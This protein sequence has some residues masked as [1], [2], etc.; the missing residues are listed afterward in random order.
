MKK[1][2]AST[3]RAMLAKV[4]V[5]AMV[6]MAFAVVAPKATA[7]A[8]AKPA[9]T[10]TSRNILVG[11][12]YDLGVKNAPAGSTYVWKTSNKKVATVDKK[13]VVVAKSKGK[14]TITCTVTDSKKKTYKL[15]CKVTVIKPANKV[16][17]SNEATVLNL[18]QKYDLN[19]TVIPASS[20]DTVSWTSDDKTIAAP[21]KNG[22]FTALKQGTVTITAKTLSGKKVSVTIEVVDAEGLVA[23]QA[24]LNKMLG[25]GA[26]VITLKTDA[27]EDFVI[28]NGDYSNQKL[29][30]DVPN[31][32]V[33]NN[34]NFASIEIKN[35]KADTWYEGAKGNNIEVTSN[36]VRIYVNAGAS[37]GIVVKRVGS[38]IVLVNDGVVTELSVE[39]A[40]N[41]EIIGTS[42]EPIPVV[43]EV[44]NI[45]I[46]TSVPL[47][48]TSKE[49]ISLTLNKGA[50]GTTISVESQDKVPAISGVAGATISV[51]PSDGS[52]PAEVIIRN[53]EAGPTQGGGAGGG[54]GGG[55]GGNTGGLTNE[56]A[57][58][59]GDTFTLSGSIS[60][61][62]SAKVIL[63]GK[64]SYDIN[65]A[66]LGKLMSY[67]NGENA[68]IDKW[69]S[70]S[71]PVTDTEFFPV[72]VTG[73]SDRSTKKVSFGGIE[74]TVTVNRSAKTITVNGN[75][76]LSKNG[77][78]Q[79][80]ITNAPT[81]LSFFVTY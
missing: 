72:T 50:E 13:G 23:D 32:D 74:Y 65:G 53:P 9:L 80:T 55:D 61:V 41:I 28:P 39:A 66:M 59:N 18:G 69:E 54:T 15:T 2:Y 75:Y 1:S 12:L 31:S 25:S 57:K 48:L 7:Q 46:A 29:I 71:K 34:G 63:D 64:G 70:I 67:L 30:V 17:I 10:K 21:D 44:E 16:I 20:N 49:K 3:M 58:R 76:V 42:T 4:L 47:E 52:K 43:T 8:A 78:N 68:A 81:N 24:G 79:L 26:E 5:F 73:T 40:A 22:K 51:G 56:Y 62:K 6:M 27:A 35:I 45:N 60:N 37:A 19:A 77:N 38:S 11:D 14:A 33:H 36:K